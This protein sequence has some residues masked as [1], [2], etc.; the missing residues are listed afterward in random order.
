MN[1]SPINTGK[2][3]L[4]R[5]LVTV[6]LALLTMAALLPAGARQA[7]A[8]DFATDLVAVATAEA[9][10]YGGRHECNS[11]TMSARVGQYWSS[12][13]LNLNG[14]NRDVPWSA[15]F[16]SYMM[17]EAN[18]GSEFRYSSA[19][20]V[21]IHDA[22]AGGRGLYGSVQDTNSATARPGDLVCS[23]RGRVAN[24]TY[25]SFSS[26]YSRGGINNDS[27][28]THCDIV[29][30][31]SG[32][33]VTVVGGNVGQ[34]VTRKTVSLTSYAILLPV[35][36][37]TSTPDNG[38]N[39]SGT[40]EIIGKGG[41]CLDLPGQNTANGTDLWIYSCNG[42]VAQSWTLDNG[43][44][45]VMGKCLDIEGTEQ[46]GSDVQI[47]LCGYTGDLQWYV[48][49]AG[50]IKSARFPA[51]C[52]DIR[53]GSTTNRTPVQMWTCNGTAAQQ[54]VTPS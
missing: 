40:G 47:T 44:F 6:A 4:V 16:V 17:R 41:K 31:T 3:S 13:G 45:R 51:L 43:E 49:S 10:S 9:N 36:G 46:R 48:T 5:M 14:C 25:N 8:A 53:W 15:A 30:A 54:W 1:T 42:T 52:L 20:R 39:A 38:G 50:E 22:F 34:T 19:H 24:W 32:N 33:N 11:S 7:D 21:Y 27:I 23:G 26:W 2:R 35:A 18:A 37:N 29:T 12:L 28:P